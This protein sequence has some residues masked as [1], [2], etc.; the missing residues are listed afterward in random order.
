MRFPYY[1]GLSGRLFAPLS[2]ALVINIGVYNDFKRRRGK[3]D[4]EHKRV[5]KRELIR[6]TVFAGV[7]K[8]LIIGGEDIL[9]FWRAFY[10]P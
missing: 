5:I 4:Y 2:F 6:P 9:T 3:S 7:C 10:L 8:K 1:Y